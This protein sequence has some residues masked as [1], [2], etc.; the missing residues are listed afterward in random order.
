MI[1]TSMAEPGSVFPSVKGSVALLGG[2]IRVDSAPGSGSQFIF[3]FPTE[4]VPVTKQPESIPL[5]V[6]P[7]EVRYTWSGKKILVVED[8]P[9]NL[10]YPGHDSEPCRCRTTAVTGKRGS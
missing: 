4:F 10:D 6:Q 7:E 3:T 1:S 5:S 2:T 8:E 9:S